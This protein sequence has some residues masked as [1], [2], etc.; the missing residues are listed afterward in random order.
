MSRCTQLRQS[1]SCIRP[2]LLLSGGTVFVCRSAEKWIGCILVYKWRWGVGGVINIVWLLMLACAMAAAIRQGDIGLF[3]DGVLRGASQAV[4]LAFS[5]V[6]VM[7]LWMGL[8]ALLE[9]SG[10]LRRLAGLLSPLL[11]RLFPELP[12]GSPALQCI[13]LNFCANLL[14]LGNAATP[15]GLKAM[16]EL[17]KLNPRPDTASNSMITL[18]L[19]NTSAVT[20]LPTTIIALR[21]AAG[22]ADPAD[23]VPCC[24]LASLGG[25]LVGL[26]VHAVIRRC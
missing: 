6:G 26:I 22:A 16:G 25:M 8:L 21:S 5:L 23:I 11:G 17:Q 7:M 1:K 20:L 2:F 15:F 12:P 4:E 18:L 13:A 9:Q 3:T 14:G 10:L 19:L 24:V